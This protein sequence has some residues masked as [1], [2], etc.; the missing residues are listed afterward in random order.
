MRNEEILIVFLVN[1]M[2]FAICYRNSIDIRKK[3]NFE[4]IRRPNTCAIR[5]RERE[6]KREERRIGQQLQ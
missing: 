1:L 4:T 2:N 6:R 3:R 5:K